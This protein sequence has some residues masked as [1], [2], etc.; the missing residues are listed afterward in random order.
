[1]YVTLE[2]NNG[3]MDGTDNGTLP[4]VSP[5]VGARRSRYD[6][7]CITIQ[8]R[9]FRFFFGTPKKRRDQM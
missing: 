5:D 3:G 2:S 8:L 1:M 6:A 9:I 7:W 4:D